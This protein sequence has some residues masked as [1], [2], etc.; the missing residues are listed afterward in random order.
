ME[1]REIFRKIKI[2]PVSVF[3]DV[4]SALKT[5]EI[6]IKHKVNVIEVT[7]R[8]ENAF[9]CI[10]AIL[11]E[12]PSAIAGAGS[13]L[14]KDALKRAVD[15]GAVFA[16]APCIDKEV[17]KFAAEVK[18]PFIPGISTPSELNKALKYSNMIKLFPAQALGGTEYLNSITAPFRRFNFDLIPTGGIDNKNY[19]NYLGCEKVLACGLSYPVAEKL[20]KEKDFLSIERRIMEVYGEL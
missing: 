8:T 9:D 14:D 17:A 3:E 10:A 12:F 1:L 11:K 6:L 7:L 5:A 4:T 13:V 20:L 2:I 16:V 18:I 19:M 15:S